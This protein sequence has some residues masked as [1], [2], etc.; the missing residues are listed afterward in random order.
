MP[1]T[2][3]SQGHVSLRPA[4]GR[5]AY[6]IHVPI[7]ILHRVDDDSFLRLVFVDESNHFPATEV[8]PKDRTTI[9]VVGQN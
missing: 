2:S 8:T 3:R 7:E 9:V 6:L 4:S 1:R 5:L